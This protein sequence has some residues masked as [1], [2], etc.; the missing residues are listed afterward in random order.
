VGALLQR[1]NLWDVRKKALSGYSGGMRQ[2]FGIA[3]A[4][5]GEPTLLI[6]DEPTP[7]PRSERAQS[8]LQSAFRSW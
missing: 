2:R 3:Q 6:V 7:R 5:I 1:V 4:L 8:I